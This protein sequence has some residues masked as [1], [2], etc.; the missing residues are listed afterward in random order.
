M[1]NKLKKYWIWI[2]LSIALIWYFIKNKKTNL[3]TVMDVDHKNIKGWISAEQDEQLTKNF[4]LK[5]FHS[6]DGSDMPIEVYHNIKI[7]A[8][9]LQKLRDFWN[10][11]IKIN[12]AYRSPQHNANTPGAATNSFHMKG[13][14][15]DIT[16]NGLTPSEVRYSVESLI[17]EGFVKFGG[18]GKYNNFTHL[19]IRNKKARW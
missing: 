9:E 13:M 16:A 3:L 5:E 7:L 15:A 11:P 4:R 19:D 1:K 2:V 17:K 8:N 18:I 10:T 6:K 14:A 12:S